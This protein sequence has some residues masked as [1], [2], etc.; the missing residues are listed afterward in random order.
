MV[1]MDINWI[2]FIWATIFVD[3]LFATILSRLWPVWFFVF[4]TIEHKK[5][6]AYIKR[7]NAEATLRAVGYSEPS[8]GASARD[9]KDWEPISP[10]QWALLLLAV[11][12]VVLVV[13]SQLGTTGAV[14]VAG[15]VESSFG[16]A[17]ASAAGLAT[18]I[19]IGVSRMAGVTVNTMTILPRSK[20]T[21][22]PEA[23][24][25]S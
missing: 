22:K 24:Q 8:D 16:L 25:L 17:L 21:S 7:R 5:P 1:A 3:T 19:R 15:V 23:K 2:F 6:M 14:P 13:Y 11:P 12:G 4:T 9:G 10:G 20:N 18:A